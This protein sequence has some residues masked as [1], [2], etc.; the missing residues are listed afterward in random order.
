[1]KKRVFFCFKQN[2]NSFELHEY[3]CVCVGEL[4]FVYDKDILQYPED[5]QIPFHF[6]FL[7][8]SVVHLA[9]TD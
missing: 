8:F 4:W 2:W 6:N 5:Q 7:N 1:M 3:N 9:I